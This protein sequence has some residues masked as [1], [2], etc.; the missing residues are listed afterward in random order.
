MP[1]FQ[2]KTLIIIGAEAF[3]TNT[4][5]NTFSLKVLVV[6]HLKHVYSI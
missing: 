3:S 6:V 1:P 5:T 4:T 2:R